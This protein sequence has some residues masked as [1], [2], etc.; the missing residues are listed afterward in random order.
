MTEAPPFFI[1][2]SA[3]SG[4]TMLR[5]MLNR[6]SKV[7]VPTESRLITEL[8][9]GS[10]QVE[11]CHYLEQLSERPRFADW[12]VPIAAVREELGDAPLVSYEEALSATYRAYAHS[13]GKERW[14]IKT[15]RYVEQIP[16]IAEIFPSS[17]FVHLVRDGRDVALSYADLTFGPKSVSS[18]AHLWAKRV[19]AGL[20]DGRPLGEDR[21]M[22]LRYEDLVEESETELRRLCDFLGITFEPGMLEGAGSLQDD[23][24][25]KAAIYNRHVTDRPKRGVRQWRTGMPDRHVEIFEAVAGSVLS[26]LNYPRLYPH[27]GVVARIEAYLGG[28]GFPVGRVASLARKLMLNVT[29]KPGSRRSSP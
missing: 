1:V 11:P 20:R 13:R 14:G 22:E 29:G 8:W 16:F 26:E 4:T 12:N 2:A 10:K 17:R 6:H 23:V 15:P 3:R 21:Y 9:Q 28:L 7:A 19:S 27:P 5:L 25:P 18:S 24:L